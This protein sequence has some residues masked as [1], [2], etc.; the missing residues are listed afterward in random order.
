MK[1]DKHESSSTGKGISKA[2]SGG[3]RVPNCAPSVQ[4]QQ[5]KA[6][7]N[8]HGNAQQEQSIRTPV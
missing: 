4:L 7:L 2:V 6:H 8:A 1:L 5:C 3:N